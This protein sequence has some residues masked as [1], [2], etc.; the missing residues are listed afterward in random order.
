MSEAKFLGRVGR[1]R[2]HNDQPLL[3]YYGPDFPLTHFI[4]AS[5]AHIG[6]R[7][8]PL[9]P[10][11]RE[12]IG[13]AADAGLP[14][15][16]VTNSRRPW[17]ERHFAAHNL[18]AR[19]HTIVTRDDCVNGKPDPEPYERCARAFGLAPVDVLAIEDSPAGVASAY[20]AG[21]MVVVVPDLLAPDE[22]TRARAL[23]KHA[24]SEVLALVATPQPSW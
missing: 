24:L 1:H 17:V 12:L 2:D 18:S 11:A 20:G 7:A 23:V 9:K 6:E 5:R 13:Q 14:L 21:L 3:G 16:L 19:F 22:D 15:A 10:G 4:E 8:A